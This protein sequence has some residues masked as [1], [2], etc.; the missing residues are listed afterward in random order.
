MKQLCSLMTV[1]TVCFA[2]A[3]TKEAKQ[4]ILK[5]HSFFGE[6]RIQ[7]NDKIAVPE[8]GQIL[9]VNDVIITGKESVVDVVYRNAGIIRIH[10][11]T[12]VTIQSLLNNNADDVTLNIDSGKTFA[13]LGKLKKGDSFALK[14]KTVIAAVRGTSFRMVA[15]D[16]G[17]Q[18]NVIAGKVMVK[19]VSNETVVEDVEVIVEENQTVALDTK[20]VE[21]IVQKIEEKKS[22]TYE[23]DEQQKIIEELKEKIKPVETPKEALKEIKKEVKDIPVVAVAHEEV[24]QEISRVVEDDSETRKQQEEKLL[25]DKEEKEKAEKAL[26]LRMEKEKRE[27]LLAEKMEKERLEKEKL[28]KE[29]AEREK[30]AKEQKI[31]EDRV[32]NI[33]TL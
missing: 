7:T 3:C 11:N 14:S 12:K 23:K 29:Q 24:K 22:E 18:V 9:S 28:A 10:E 13:T 33:P 5:I 26:K 25:K 17:A 32:K 31:K 15:D 4:D 8:V 19:P 16:K 30:A 27:K 1:L 6:V 20:T 21:T 2:I